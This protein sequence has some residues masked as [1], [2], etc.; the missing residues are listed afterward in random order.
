MCFSSSESS[1]SGSLQRVVELLCADEKVRSS[2]DHSPARFDAHRVHEQ[3]QWGQHFGDSAAIKGG[4]DMNSMQ[5]FQSCSFPEDPLDRL[6][7]NE[8]RVIFDPV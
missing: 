2:L 5:I 3:C 7:A 6:C 4:T 8:R 1:T